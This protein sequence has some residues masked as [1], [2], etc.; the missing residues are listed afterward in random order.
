[1]SCIT[2]NDFCTRTECVDPEFCQL[3][4][5]QGA[6]CVVCAGSMQAHVQIDGK[7]VAPMRNN[8]INVNELNVQ[9]IILSL[10]VFVMIIS[11][12]VIMI[13]NC[14]AKCGWTNW[15]YKHIPD[16]ESTNI[17]STGKTIRAIDDQVDH[18]ENEKKFQN[19]I[20]I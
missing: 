17:S 13:R 11:L 15:Q 5:Q 3:A 10:I 14:I 2:F 9:T 1:M 7:K 6:S 4:A 8:G 19:V 16:L 12:L 20:L 18:D